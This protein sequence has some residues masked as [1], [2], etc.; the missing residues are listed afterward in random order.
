MKRAWF[1]GETVV[2]SGASGG[3]GKQVCLQLVKKYGAKVVGIGR[4]EK[5]MQALQEELGED[6]QNFCYRLFDV[7]VYE[8]WLS[9]QTWLQEKQIFPVL[10]LNNAGAFP[11]FFPADKTDVS[12][13]ERLLHTNYLSCV[14]AVS[15]LLPM[16]KKPDKGLGG[17]VNVCSSAALCSVVGTAPYSAS[18]GALKG[19]TEA[20]SLENKGKYYIGIVYP[21][22]TAT[23]LFREDKNTDGSIL[24][25][26]ATT[27]EKMA[28]KIVKAIR[29]RK[30]R[31]VLGADAK[32]MNLLAKIAP[33]KGLG[34]IARV[35]KAS[36]SKVF[37]NVFER[38]EKK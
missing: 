12:V 34:L 6:G 20:L 26:V 10:L 11:T 1:T 27:P 24:Y 2:V 29:R 38:K 19:Y 17:V 31:A 25:K 18:K 35:M 22:T 30:R 32:L 21:G 7:G 15:T 16:V 28:K 5:K 33:V 14:Y 36:G 23:D 9:F 3:I 8:N 37:S 13:Y 4:D